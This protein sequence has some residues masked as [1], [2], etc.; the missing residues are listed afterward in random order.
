MKL[1]LI[2]VDSMRPSGGIER[3]ITNLCNEWAKEYNVEIL[4]KDEP[5]SFYDLD[6]RVKIASLQFPFIMD[7]SS[8]TSRVLN[9]IKSIFLTR[10]K[11]NLYIDEFSPDIIYT[12]NPVNSLEICLLGKRYRNR[13]VI[14]EHGSKYGY[15]RIYKILK[16]IIYP[17]SRYVSV[18]TLTDTK[19]YLKE[20]I[21]AVY[22]PHLTTFKIVERT[23]PKENIVLNIG[24]LTSDKN[25][26][27]LL[28]IWNHLKQ[29]EPNNDWK[30]VIVGKGEKLDELEK[31]VIAHNLEN[32]VSIVQPTKL[33]SKYYEKSSIFAF[34]SKFEGFGMVLLEAM[35]FGIPCISF[36]CPSGPRDIVIDNV[37]GYLVDQSDSTG[38]SLKLLELMNNTKKLQE[39]GNEAFKSATE[40]DNTTILELW[41]QLFSD[42]FD[43][44]HGDYGGHK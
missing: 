38:F 15:N 42:I 20:N 34:T 21:N 24:R 26:I 43:Q 40:W 29:K 30:L 9:L 39:M 6:S 14:S 10:K 28:K 5:E 44:N 7:M 33:I 22:I 18:P 19:S 35:S 8:R 32:S 12:S 36:D 3:V 37:N 4:V 16:R 23:Q 27:E 2:Y 13:L 31:Y 17:L 41:N 25:Q 1:I 11:L